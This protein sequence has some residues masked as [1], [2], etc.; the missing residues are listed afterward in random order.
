ME[1]EIRV[2]CHCRT[3]GDKGV[4][5][6]PEHTFRQVLKNL[7]IRILEDRVADS[8]DETDRSRKILI[9]FQINGRTVNLS[10]TLR[11]AGFIP[12]APE[13]PGTKPPTAKY[14][15]SGIE[16]QLDEEDPVKTDLFIHLPDEGH[17]S[18]EMPL[19]GYNSSVDSM[20]D[21][22]FIGCRRH[23][24]TAKKPKAK[25]AKWTPEEWDEWNR[26]QEEAKK[27][28]AA[29]KAAAKNA[30][31]EKEQQEWRKYEEQEIQGRLRAPCP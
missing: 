18:C 11:S 15:V 13:E 22:N 3:F 29:A 14:H 16:G 31:W 4:V 12:F 1:G 8:L 6:L 27:E 26:Q 5:R 7:R 21:E 28:K 23:L 10:Q 9:G 2:V 17:L 24:Q 30:K 20:S 25:K 19:P